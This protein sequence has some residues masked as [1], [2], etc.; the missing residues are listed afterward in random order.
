MFV[1]TILPLKGADLHLFQT[2][3]VIGWENNRDGD[4]TM[5]LSLKTIGSAGY[6]D[7]WNKRFGWVHVNRLKETNMGV[8]QVFDRWKGDH[9][10][11]PPVWRRFLFDGHFFS[12]K[13]ILALCP[14]FITPYFI[15]LAL[16]LACA[17]G[18]HLEESCEVTWEQHASARGGERR[19]ASTL[20][21]CS[22]SSGVLT[23]VAACFTRYKAR[24]RYDRC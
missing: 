12:G 21:S 22:A 6:R 15:L 5:P 19:G 9:V 8:V 11:T 20:P 16:S 3:F 7:Q 23:R 4:I 24:F 2:R 17:L 18:L 10:P 1:G 13:K 14:F